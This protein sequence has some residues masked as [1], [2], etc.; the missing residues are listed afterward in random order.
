MKLDEAPR[1]NLKIFATT[2]LMIG[3]VRG[4]IP[5]LS[6]QAP[7][8]AYQL[9]SIDLNDLINQKRDSL[10]RNKPSDSEK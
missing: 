5:T 3:R 8:G 1:K 9:P 10:A 4:L 7:F 6:G 2:N